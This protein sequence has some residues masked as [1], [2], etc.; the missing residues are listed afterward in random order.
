MS[1]QT[2]SSVSA[3][4]TAGARR[5]SSLALAGWLAAVAIVFGIL[6]LVF[7]WASRSAPGGGSAAATAVGTPALDL[8]AADFRLASLD[9]R[10]LGPRDFLGK[11]VVIDFWAT[12][13]GPC[14]LQ[15][16]YLEKLHQELPPEKVQFL[17]ISLGEDEPTVR[18][19]TEKSPFPYPV[20]IDPEDAVTHRYKIYG[21]PTVMVIDPRGGIRF[22][23]SNVVDTET[24]RSEIA[25]AGQLS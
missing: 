18:A 25:K 7:G 9:G 6:A 19:F 14:R 5:R 15:A 13:C 17:A 22:M 23:E 11:V 10:Q 8:P 1:T 3:P 21:L 16:A 24:L 4:P 20:L 2:L 12:W